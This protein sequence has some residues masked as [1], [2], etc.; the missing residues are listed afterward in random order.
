MSFEDTMKMA[1]KQRSLWYDI[2]GLEMH[3]P[4]PKIQ[5]AFQ[6]LSRITL[7]NKLIKQSVRMSVVKVYPCSHTARN[8][9]RDLHR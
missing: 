3:F 1:S 6:T 2:Y 4:S 8:R 5:V 9:K 7:S